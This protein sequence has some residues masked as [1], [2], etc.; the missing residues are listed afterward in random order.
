MRRSL[1]LLLVLLAVSGCSYRIQGAPVAAP[2]PPLS[3]ETPRKTA[4]VDACKLLTEADL[5]PL[6]SLLF[7]PA[8]RVEIPNS[9]LFTMKENAYVLVVVPYRSLDESRR[10]QSKGREIVTSKHSTWL[11]CGKQE[12]EMVCTATIAVTRTESLMVAIGMGGDIPEARAQASLQ[13]LSVEA[14]KR[15]PAA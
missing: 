6:G 7:V 9:C 12:T 4:G 11:S 10:I 8:P 5:K 13:P 14:L 1:S 2:P 15:M 3:I